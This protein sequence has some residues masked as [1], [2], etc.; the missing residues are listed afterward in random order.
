LVQ[1]AD[2]QGPSNEGRPERTMGASEETA[3]RDGDNIVFFFFLHELELS[4]DVLQKSGESQHH[5]P[6]P[7]N[8]G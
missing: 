8:T 5:R 7:G 3:A 6:I 2:G 1:V 4:A